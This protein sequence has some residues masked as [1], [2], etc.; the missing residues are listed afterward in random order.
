LKRKLEEARVTEICFSPDLDTGKMMAMLCGPIPEDLLRKECS[1]AGRK[2]WSDS[3]GGS[4]AREVIAVLCAPA[5]AARLKKKPLKEWSNEGRRGTRWCDLVE[6]LERP[7]RL[8]LAKKVVSSLERN[9]SAMLGTAGKFYRRASP[10]AIRV[11]DAC[12]RLACKLQRPP[13]RKEL[14][15]EAK[16]PG[17]GIKEFTN[18]LRDV[19]LAWL[20][21]DNAARGKREVY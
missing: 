16:R 8:V 9:Q 18:L 15:E 14:M 6:L 10:E 21:E 1:R 13:T 20:K 2:L 5:L 17:G 19:G 7:N 4:P 3:F 11:L 12:A